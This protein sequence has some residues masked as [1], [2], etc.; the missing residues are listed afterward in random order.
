MYR[1]AVYTQ[2]CNEGREL[3]SGVTRVEGYPAVVQERW[4]PGGDIPLPHLGR[5]LDCPETSRYTPWV[6]LAV[7]T[8]TTV[9]QQGVAHLPAKTPWAQS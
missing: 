3:P 6:H 8:A 4:Y 1:Q 7:I 2:R 5:P 9:P